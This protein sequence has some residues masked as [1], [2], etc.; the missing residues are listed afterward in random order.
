MALAW[1]KMENG[2][3]DMPS[4][5]LSLCIEAE[6]LERASFFWVFFCAGRLRCILFLRGYAGL[7]DVRDSSEGQRRWACLR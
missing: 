5:S 1:N 2:G 7:L 6:G 4:R 3:T